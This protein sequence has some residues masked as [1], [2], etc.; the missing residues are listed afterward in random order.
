MGHPGT[1]G[2]FHHAVRSIEVFYADRSLETFEMRRWLV[3]VAAP[4]RLHANRLAH[5]QLT[6]RHV[7]THALGTALGTNAGDFS[8][9]IVKSDD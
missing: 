7:A 9:L 1:D 6:T 5:L 4:A 8:N 3:L 2:G